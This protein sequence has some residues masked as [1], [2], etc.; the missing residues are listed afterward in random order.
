MQKF[1]EKYIDS[2]EYFQLYEFEAEINKMRDS[3]S[4]SKLQVFLKLNANIEELTFEISK[5]STFGVSFDIKKLKA[6]L[7]VREKNYQVSLSMQDM[8]ANVFNC[9]KAQKLKTYVPII[10]RNCVFDGI[11]DLLQIKY[12]RNP[13]GKPFVFH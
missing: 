1:I 10:K 8:Q 5:E 2:V 3:T 7:I 13:I 11:T 9:K 12:E 4:L 6:S